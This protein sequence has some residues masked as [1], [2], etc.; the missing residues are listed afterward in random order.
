[1]LTS[2]IYCAAFRNHNPNVHKKIY[3]FTS[4]LDIAHVDIYIEV[5]ISNI[6]NCVSY[7]LLT[8]LIV[9][10]TNMYTDLVNRSAPAFQKHLK[11]ENEQVY[12]GYQV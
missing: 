7:R 4:V 12:L 2:H 3:A 8:N 9:A 5:N 11:T 10:A 6:N 1:M